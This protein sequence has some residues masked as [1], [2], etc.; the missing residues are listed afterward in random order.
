M[1][2]LLEAK[3]CNKPSALSQ[4][5]TSAPLNYYCSAARRYHEQNA[6]CCPRR[7]PTRN[8][9]YCQVYHK[10]SQANFGL[11]F[12]AFCEVYHGDSS[13]IQPLVRSL[14]YSSGLSTFFCTANHY[15]NLTTPS[16]ILIKQTLTQL[17]R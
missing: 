15:Y 2:C 10:L 3:S 16:K 11:K 14:L 17:S 8:F 1:L 9:K 13:F 6:K 7:K 5:Q 4:Q 12:R